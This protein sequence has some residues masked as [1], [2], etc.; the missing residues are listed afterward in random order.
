MKFDDLMEY[1]KIH[2][3]GTY[4]AYPLIDNKEK[5][6]IVKRGNSLMVATDEKTKNL[7]KILGKEFTDVHPERLLELSKLKTAR[8]KQTIVVFGA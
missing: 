7:I 8:F 3:N 4:D 5:K 1:F 2:E 6:V